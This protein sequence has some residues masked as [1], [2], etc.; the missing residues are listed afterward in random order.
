MDFEGRSTWTAAQLNITGSFLCQE[1]NKHA[2][3]ETLRFHKKT[4][5]RTQ[6]EAAVLHPK[7]IGQADKHCTYQSLI[8][9]A[10]LAL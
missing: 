7:M 2:L 3:V 6:F 8:S 9:R 5:T 10:A 1:K 4:F